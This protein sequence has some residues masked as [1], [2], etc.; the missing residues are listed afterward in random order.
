MVDSPH[1]WST[2]DD[3]IIDLFVGDPS[4]GLGLT[5]QSGFI[6]LTIEKRST[7]KFWNG[8]T[9]VASATLSMTEVD[10][11][12][13]PGLYR[14]VLDSSGNLS[15]EQFFVHASISNPPTIEGDDYSIHITKDV[16]TVN[17][18]ESEPRV[19]A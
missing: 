5:G 8:S 4:T 7:G 19:I 6:T 10:S 16:T 15:E 18:Y 14:Y 13:S 9:Y 3:I 11:S 17:L 2:G 1:T 12:N